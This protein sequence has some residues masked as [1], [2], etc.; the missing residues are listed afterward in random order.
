[1]CKPKILKN[2]EGLP[3][4]DF[5]V[6]TQ[7]VTIYSPHFQEPRYLEWDKKGKCEC[8]SNGAN[9]DYF[10]DG[11]GIQLKS[12]RFNTL[13]YVFFDFPTAIPNACYFRVRMKGQI[14]YIPYKNELM[15]RT[16]DAPATKDTVVRIE[17]SIGRSEN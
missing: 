1:M 7:G 2:F 11:N 14:H 15:L 3:E 8:Q 16:S 9:I 12:W 6:S 10:I 5:S 13:R 17:F 4:V